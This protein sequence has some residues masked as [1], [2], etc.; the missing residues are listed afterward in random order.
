M[1][2][3]PLYLLLLAEMALYLIILQLAYLHMLVQ[4]MVT[5]NRKLPQ[6]LVLQFQ[7]VLFLLAKLLVLQMM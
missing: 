7:V 5:F 3:V 4:L 6:V 2:H 1:L